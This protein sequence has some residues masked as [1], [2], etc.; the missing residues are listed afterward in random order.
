[1][2][3]TEEKPAEVPVTEQAISS[4]SKQVEVDADTSTQ[5][6]T[7]VAPTNEEPEPEVKMETDETQ[8]E[9]SSNV[10]AEVVEPMETK[11][12]E[13]I[14]EP[15]AETE[16]ET[17]EKEVEDVEPAKKEVEVIEKDDE[18]V[19]VSDEKDVKEGA[20]E[21]TPKEL[22]EEKEIVVEDK[23]DP[24]VAP[25]SCEQVN[26]QVLCKEESTEI[27]EDWDVLGTDDEEGEVA[28]DKKRSGV[29]MPNANIIIDLYQKLDKEG[30]LELQ[31]KCPGRRQPEKEKTENEETEKMEEEIETKE[32]EEKKEEEEP[33]EFDFDIDTP[34]ITSMTPRRTPGSGHAQGSGK[35]RVARMD[36]IF[37][38]MMRHKRIDEELQ[39]FGEDD[40]EPNKTD[41]TPQR[42]IGKFRIRKDF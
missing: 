6:E 5:I 13:P 27:I 23:V 42:A 26:E 17:K 21:E 37:N 19:K 16:P 35:K 39:R 30:V 38:D 41:T 10:N 22:V 11:P 8:L 20:V 12:A 1:M 25:N 34:S 3:A 36:K 31:W 9:D 32:T 28:Q 24:V 15:I 4:E 14:A 33:T 2:M 40:D 29:W 7:E 18:E